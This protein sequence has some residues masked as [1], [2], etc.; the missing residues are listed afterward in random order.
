MVYNDNLNVCRSLNSI[1]S[2]TA[3]KRLMT[4]I[5]CIREILKRGE[6]DE[7]SYVETALNVADALT[8]STSANVLHEVLTEN[9]L[10][11]SDYLDLRK[12]K[13][14]ASAKK[15]YLIKLK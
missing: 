14:R 4:Y 8:K 9:M 15:Q 3:E 6:V 11:V 1:T 2:V 12:K 13:N 10:R 5:G 7:I